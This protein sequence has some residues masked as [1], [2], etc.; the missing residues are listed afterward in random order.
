MPRRSHYGNEPPRNTFPLC[1]AWRCRSV[2]SPPQTLVSFDRA[3]QLL[4]A[5]PAL[6][7]ET[8]PRLAAHPRR[9]RQIGRPRTRTSPFPEGGV[10]C[11]C[12][13]PDTGTENRICRW[14]MSYMTM[15]PSAAS[16]R[17]LRRVS[18]QVTR[19]TSWGQGLSRGSIRPRKKPGDFG[20]YGASTTSQ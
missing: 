11:V 13:T 19:L 3:P 8:G 10:L 5:L 14:V 15:T 7:R 17:L 1:G 4:A 12:S 6:L 9:P 2:I 16:M 18:L 20:H